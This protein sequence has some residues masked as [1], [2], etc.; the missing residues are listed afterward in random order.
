MSKISTFGLIPQAD[1]RNQN[2]FIKLQTS[3]T[4]YLIYSIWNFN[5]HF[6]SN[7]S[8]NNIDI[9]KPKMA[10]SCNLP[11]MAVWRQYVLILIN[12]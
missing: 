9:N 12:S 8:P 4:K 10:S 2:K 3:Q 6:C 1:R 7:Y 5:D 11:K